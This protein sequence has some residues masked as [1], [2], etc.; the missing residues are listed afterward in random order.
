M[1]S[2]L[3]GNDTTRIS[4]N[5]AALAKGVGAVDNLSAPLLGDLNLLLARMALVKLFVTSVAVQ[6]LWLLR[7]AVVVFLLVVVVNGSQVLL[8]VV[9]FGQ[10]HIYIDVVNAYL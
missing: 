5:R 1:F 6:T 2:R 10:T 7:D 4:A 8:F 3:C 9:N